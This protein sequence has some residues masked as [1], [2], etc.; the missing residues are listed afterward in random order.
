MIT[1]PLPKKKQRRFCNNCQGIH[2]PPTGAKCTEVSCTDELSEVT[3]FEDCGDSAFSACSDTDPWNTTIVPNP[4]LSLRDQCIG[5]PKERDRRSYGFEP[6]IP[7]GWEQH[8]QKTDNLNTGR[9]IESRIDGGDR[10]F[11]DEKDMEN[12]MARLQLEF[13]NLS[14]KTNESQDC[15]VRIEQ[16]LKEQSGGTQVG[17]RHLQRSRET[18]KILQYAAMEQ[19]VALG[20]KMADGTTCQLHDHIRRLLSP[21]QAHMGPHLLPHQINL[22]L[23]DALENM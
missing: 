6:Q 4:E 12:H 7:E 21:R 15:L 18:V 1:A 23:V 22:H 9:H 20:S 19:E 2:F 3:D 11:W 8:P 16:L 17:C 5:F 10:I 13:R 14:V